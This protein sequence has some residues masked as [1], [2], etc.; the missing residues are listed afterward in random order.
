[1]SLI[2]EGGG[3]LVGEQCPGTVKI[4]CN[5][6]DLSF[7]RWRYNG[8]I[9]IETFFSDTEAPSSVNPSNPAFVYRVELL[10][11]AQDP[12]ADSSIANFSSELVVNMSNLRTVSILHVGIQEFQ[13]RFQWMLRLYK[14]LSLRVPMKLM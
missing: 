3:S 7:L 9:N 11:V 8:E 5:G 2:V 10:S 13:K 12:A 6:V 14:K 4:L 1:M